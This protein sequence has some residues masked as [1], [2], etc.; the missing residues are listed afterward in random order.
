[1]HRICTEALGIEFQLAQLLN[2]VLKAA[3]LSHQPPGA[4]LTW[5]NFSSLRIG[6]HN[7]SRAI[8]SPH[9]SFNRVRYART[10]EERTMIDARKYLNNA[11]NCMELAESATDP[12]ARA[13]YLRMAQGWLALLEEQE[14]LEG[15][16]SPLS[17]TGLRPKQE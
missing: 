10:A 8:M 5:V 9:C 2:E 7:P 3:D 16:V 11:E 14:W 13:R 1:M 17:E 4:I 6:Y 12:P 15:K